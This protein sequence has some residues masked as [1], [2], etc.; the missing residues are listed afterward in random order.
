MTTLYEAAKSFLLPVSTKRSSPFREVPG[1]PTRKSLVAFFMAAMLAVGPLSPA[2]AQS[3]AQN[4]PSNPAPAASVATEGSSI[5]PV[6]SLGLAKYNFTN[7]PRAFPNLLKPYQQIHIDEPVITNSPRLQQLIH[8]GKLELSLEDAVELA[9]ENSLDIGVQ[10]Y[11]PW[12]ADASILKAKAGGSGYSTPGGLFASSTAFLPSLSYDPTVTSTILIDDNTIPVNNPLISGTGTG[13]A[14]LTTLETHTTQFNNEVSRGFETGTN[15][16]VSWNNARTSS[17]STANLFNP[18]VQSTLTIGFTQALLNGF[19]VAVNTRNI[20]IAKNNRKIA[21]WAFAQQAITTVTNTIT[22]YWELVYA[23]ANV[24][25]DEQAITVSQKL[26]SDNKKQLDA[27]TMAPL[28]VTRAQSELATDRQNLIVARTV[29]L[30]DEQILKNAI[31]KDPLAPEVVNVEIITTDQPT[32]PAAIENPSFEDSIK[33]A[34]EKRPELQEQL[35]NLKN[36]A[37]DIQATRNAL[38]PTLTLSGQYSSVGLAGNAP[39]GTSILVPDSQLP[40]LD[41][42]GNPVLVNGVPIFEPEQEIPVTGTNSQ[43]FT[44]AQS[45]IFHNRFPDYSAQLTLSLPLR[46]RSAQA[47]SARAILTQR[48]QEMSLQQLKNAA[49][50]DVRNT[51]IA[52]TQDRAQVDAASEARQ[53]QQETFDAEQKKYRL[54]ASTV[55]NVILTQRDLIAAQGTELRALANLEEA[56]ANYERALGRTLE[57]NHVTIADAKSGAVERETLIPGTLHGKVVGTE[58]LFRDGGS[59]SSRE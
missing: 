3:A 14:T 12:I 11:Y 41:E 31:T 24:K 18:A 57:V 9:L 58:D 46:N 32:Q 40:I 21:D 50:L 38:L 43:G 56:K 33:E 20:R 59:R 55:Y 15:L 45:Q 1:L 30:Q 37:I 27:G 51:Y 36:A 42:N 34:F 52:L 7:G 35:Y 17:T 6:S 10:R 44:T 28:D 49:L 19:G 26:Y 22:A 8:D 13:A 54:G 25:V 53:L 39:K 29:Q 16:T 23:R 4:P 5:A 2:F 47:D 48:Q